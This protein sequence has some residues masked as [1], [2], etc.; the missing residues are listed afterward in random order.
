MFLATPPGDP[1][2]ECLYCLVCCARQP[3][4]GGCS[5][6]PRRT[7][8]QA[9]AAAARA[10]AACSSNLSPLPVSGAHRL[11]EGRGLGVALL[12]APEV[13]HQLA[14]R[15]GLRLRHAQLALHLPHLRRPGGGGGKRQRTVSVKSRLVT[16]RL[17]R[18]DPEA[19]PPGFRI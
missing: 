8:A 14:L 3:P 7:A 12:L 9:K 6:R 15:A 10:V 16:T 4:A 1:W 13:L 2:N 5:H 18:G 11:R 19:V 17:S